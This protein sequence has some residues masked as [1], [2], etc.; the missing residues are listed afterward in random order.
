MKVIR[1]EYT[2][3]TLTDLVRFSLRAPSLHFPQ[4]QVELLKYE[5]VFF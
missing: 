4:L 5:F 3:E 1:V 2:K